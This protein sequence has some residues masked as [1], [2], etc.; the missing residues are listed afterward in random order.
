MKNLSPTGNAFMSSS[1]TLK[2]ETPPDVL[3]SEPDVSR[4]ESSILASKL[5]EVKGLMTIISLNSRFLT[6]REQ[7]HVEALEYAMTKRLDALREE[8]QV[9]EADIKIDQ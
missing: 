9:R 8:C 4:S 7:E 5:K 1:P 2:S 3:P 6:R